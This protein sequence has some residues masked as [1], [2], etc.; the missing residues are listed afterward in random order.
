MTGAVLSM[1]TETDALFEFP[2][3]SVA[4]PEIFWVAPSAVT[5]V[6]EGHVAIP[7]DTSAH[8]KETVT[9]ELLQP[10]A[11]AAGVADA[12][13]VGLLLSIFTVAEAVAELPALSVAVRGIICPAPSAETTTGEGQTEV[14]LNESLQLNET[15]TSELFHPAAVG[16]GLIEA[17]MLGIVLSMFSVTAAVAVFPAL[18]VAVPEITWPAPSLLTITGDGHAAIPLSASLHAYVTVT[19]ELFQPKEFGVGI[20]IAEMVGGAL[21]TPMI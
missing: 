5:V 9:S 17:L 21:S 3:L 20:A 12:E 16:D 8:V 11:F 4:L 13:I 2:A 19:L 18:S 1:L 14:P 10:A 7:L 15:I 6:G